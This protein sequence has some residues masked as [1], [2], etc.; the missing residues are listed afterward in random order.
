MKKGI[1]PKYVVATVICSCGNSFQTLSIKPEIRV[2]ICAACH[3]VFRGEVG[4]QR[5]VDT[6]G[7]VEK[8]MRK[9]RDFGQ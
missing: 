1:H 5:I 6:E 8:F 3:P 7:R 4:R 9:Y 2:E